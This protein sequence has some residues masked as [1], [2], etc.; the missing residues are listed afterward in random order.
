MKL[1]KVTGKAQLAS[2]LFSADLH[3]NKFRA[4]TLVI[5]IIH[6]NCWKITFT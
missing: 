1:I 2:T 4:L 5:V 6:L 3:D